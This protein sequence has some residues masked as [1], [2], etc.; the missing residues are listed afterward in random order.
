MLT[1][2]LIVLGYVPEGDAWESDGRRTYISEDDAT[3]A[4]MVTLT[5]ILGRHGFER[6]AVT[7]NTTALRS[8]RH[9][10]TGEI[11]EIEPGG[12]GVTGH[13]LHHM[14]AEYA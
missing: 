2:I 10:A 3:R 9:V 5:K 12:E 6:Q 11:V 4:Y 8:F 13:Y 1:D 7:E 14:K